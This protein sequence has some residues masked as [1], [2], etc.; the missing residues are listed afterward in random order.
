MYREE[1]TR[2]SI[3]YQ[4]LSRYDDMIS[5]A[6]QGG[7]SSI[8][9]T[10]PRR[11]EGYYQ[12]EESQFVEHE[13][14]NAHVLFDMMESLY[15]AISKQSGYPTELYK[16]FGKLV[17]IFNDHIFNFPENINLVANP[18]KEE[19][20]I[21]KNKEIVVAFSGG[22]DSTAL[23]LFYKNMGYKIYPVY[24]DGANRWIGIHEKKAAAKICEMLDLPIYYMSI[25]LNGFHI[26][27]EHPMK[28]MIIANAII[29]WC[30][31]NEVQPVIAFG[32]YDWVSIM[33]NNFEVCAGDTREMWIAYESIIQDIYP[34]FKIK[35]PFPKFSEAWRLLL[36]NPDVL[37]ETDSCIY[38]THSRSNFCGK[39]FKCA[40]SYIMYADYDLTEY[41]EDQYAHCIDIV[42]RASVAQLGFNHYNLKTMWKTCFF[43][44][45]EK[46][47][48][49]AW[50][51]K[52]DFRYR[53]QIFYYLDKKPVDNEE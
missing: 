10:T 15:V 8:I 47:K 20:T 37:L 23:L 4:S 53:H 44:N 7:Y 3:P 9:R 52:L 42:Y 51:K 22:K 43:Y 46:S 14:K 12:K 18:Y 35:R 32:N 50:M 41:E 11:T 1:G 38:T 31:Q 30:I 17:G 40:R 48:M 19:N 34:T 33:D 39:C 24:V 6:K 25:T 45:I 29:H 16:S 36:E 5:R 28:N 2:H 21:I 49:Y 26:Y 27:H 13:Y